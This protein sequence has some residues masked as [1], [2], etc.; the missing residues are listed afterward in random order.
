MARASHGSGQLGRM[1]VGAVAPAG[2]NPARA[3]GATGKTTKNPARES[4]ATKADPHEASAH[5]IRRVAGAFSVG[6][7]WAA[8]DAADTGADVRAASHRGYLAPGL[9]VVASGRGWQ[10]VERIPDAGADEDQPRYLSL[11]QVAA[12]L[13]VGEKVV[14]EASVRRWIRVGTTAK[15]SHRA[16]AKPVFLRATVLP[17]GRVVAVEDLDAFLAE[18][19]ARYDQLPARAR[20]VVEAGRVG[21][22]GVKAEIGTPVYPAM[23]GRKHR[24]ESCT[25]GRAS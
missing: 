25:T 15:G 21:V 9:K 12:R 3:S 13:S 2:K 10:A 18:L 8:P 24:P 5:P 22:V 11:A 1:A 16:K 17:H 6:H 20:L 23:V 19:T 14:T 7:E 4:G